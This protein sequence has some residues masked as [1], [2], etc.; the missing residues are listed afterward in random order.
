MY[1][2]NLSYITYTDLQRNN[3]SHSCDRT[4]SLWSWPVHSHHALL[5]ATKY[6]GSW[7]WGEDGRM[8]GWAAAIVWEGDLWDGVMSRARQFRERERE[9]AWNFEP[10]LSQRDLR[11]P[12]WKHYCFNATFQPPIWRLL[13]FQRNLTNPSWYGCFFNTTLKHP[14]WHHYF[15]GW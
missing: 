5:G 14:I 4:A 15:P 3:Q 6:L 13:A 1:I 7:A 12:S 2:Y 10:L 11:H 8:G 9:R